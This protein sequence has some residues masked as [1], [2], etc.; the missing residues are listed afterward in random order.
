MGFAATTAQHGLNAF[1]SVVRCHERLCAQ[2]CGP[3]A[4]K[5][6]V[7]VGQERAQGD[8]SEQRAEVEA[9]GQGHDWVGFDF[10][11]AL[12]A[13]AQRGHAV[14]LVPEFRR[15]ESASIARGG[16][17][18]V[19]PERALTMGRMAQ[20]QGCPS[21]VRVTVQGAEL[22]SKVARGV[23]PQAVDFQARTRLLHELQEH[24]AV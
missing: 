5:A 8:R 18:G 10:P 21:S 15:G 24:V 16:Q 3:H 11:H 2:T 7:V 23:L 6:G 9:G 4:K 14:T 17:A 19:Q 13:L 20:R 22:G 1:C 12:A